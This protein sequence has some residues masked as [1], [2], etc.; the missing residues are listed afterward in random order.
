MDYGK[1]S[2]NNKLRGLKQK[3]TRFSSKFSVKAFRLFLMTVIGMVVVAG[4]AG[5]GAM[6]GLLST[7]PSIDTIN[8]IPEGYVTKFYY[9][10]KATLSQTL[11]GAGGNREYVTIDQIPPHVYNAFVAIEDERFWEHY[12]IDIRGIFRAASEFLTNK[13]LGSGAST[14]TQQLI[15]NQVFAGGNE[16][17]RINKVI[18]KFQEQYLAIQLEETM[19]KKLILEYYLNTINLGQGAYGVQMAAYTYFGKNVDELT[20]SEAA[21]LAALPQSPTHM[22]PYHHPDTNRNRREDVLDEMLDNKFITIDEYHEAMEDTEDVYDRITT[23]IN[24]K[25]SSTSGV[26]SYFTD[27]LIDNLIAD[28]V[29]IGY[30]HSQATNLVYKGGLIVNTTQD[31]EAQAIADRI[32]ADESNY[33]ALGQGTYYDISYALSIMMKDGTTKHLHLSDFLKYF[34]FFEKYSHTNYSIVGG[35]YNLLTINTDFIDAC[36]DEFREYWL[37]EMGYDYSKGDRFSENYTKIL[38]PQISFV[39]MDN[40][41]GAVVCLVGGRGEKQG[42]RTF[43]R[44]TDAL[45]SVGSTFKVLASFLPG[46]DTGTFTL[47]T[48]IDDCPYYYTGSNAQVHQ[49]WS[50]GA[51][52]GLQ[53][54][55]LAISYSMNIVAVKALELVGPR[56][57]FNYLKNLGF[58]TLVE[59]MT[60]PDG[61]IYS[62]IGL[63]LAL[64]GLTNG[65][66][67]IELTAGY[68]AVANKGAYNKPYYYTEVYDHNGSLLLKHTSS[69]TQ[70][71]KTSTA[72]LLTSAMEDT[73]KPGVGT[74]SQCDFK[75]YPMSVAGKSGTT[76]NTFDVWFEGFT[77]YYTGGIWMGYDTNHILE[78]FSNN[79]KKIWRKIMEEIHAVKQLEN[80]PFEKP[81][82][83]VTAKICYKSGLLAVDGLCD[84]ADG[85]STVREEY[86]AKGTQPTTFCKSHK[87]V[88]VCAVSGKLVTGYCAH[89][90]EKIL[91]VKEEP[92]LWNA[93]FDDPTMLSPTP[94]PEDF[95]PPETNSNGDPFEVKTQIEYVT[96]DTTHVMPTDYCIDC[97]P[98]DERP[99]PTPEPGLDDEDGEGGEDGEGD[100][101]GEN[102]EGNNANPESPNPTPVPTPMPN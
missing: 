82:S 101:N 2:V 74:S 84:C 10:D 66:T 12:G 36:V 42:N 73:L 52:W 49:W 100:E 30:S 64:G 57:A 46:L 39:L 11:V 15:K 32:V 77:P 97:V 13:D 48:P 34:D 95:E 102:S 1:Y 18:R 90:V 16:D 25:S 51:Y 31:F 92:E 88:N 27:E 85:G 72:Y 86:F 41:T 28:L 47:A 79:H 37:T 20:I 6:N 40:S 50:N 21:V 7:A 62:D 19:S 26:Y 96:K 70:V 22:N 99:T 3:G 8:V 98:E 17:S 93:I 35:L 58:T 59:R 23:Y 43:N 56:V 87:K 89:T 54:P 69:P 75:D 71:M 65:V 24:T 60:G 61:L 76:S 44:A 80:V 53:N 78:G 81:D 83:V 91:L 67:N 68:C 33:P 5:F 29:D 9:N 4:F 38:Q 14:I 55:R 63:P 94:T 45:R